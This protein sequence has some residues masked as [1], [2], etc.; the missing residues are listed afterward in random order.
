L[1][2]GAIA[3]ALAVGLFSNTPRRSAL[4]TG[5]TVVIAAR[6]INVVNDFLTW[7]RCQASASRPAK[8]TYTQV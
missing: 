6:T 3:A 5:A 8:T 7:Q 4:V 1:A 2:L